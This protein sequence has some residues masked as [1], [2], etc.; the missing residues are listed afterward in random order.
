MFTSESWII[1]Y[2]YVKSAI[3]F[4]KYD[5]TLES[6]QWKSTWRYKSKHHDDGSCSVIWNVDDKNHSHNQIHKLIVI[7]MNCG[8]LIA[9]TNPNIVQS[10]YISSKIKPRT[11]CDIPCINLVSYDIS[12]ACVWYRKQH[13]LNLFNFDQEVMFGLLFE[14]FW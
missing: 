1:W 5:E 4:G 2:N 13:V 14:W 8:N 9:L 3:N 7:L 12:L 11:W 10:N 6:T